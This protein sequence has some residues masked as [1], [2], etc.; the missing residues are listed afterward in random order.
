MEKRKLNIIIFI[1][2]I[3]CSAIAMVYLPDI[4][5]SYFDAKGNII[6]YASK[7]EKLLIYPIVSLLVNALLDF[8]EKRLFDNEHRHISGFFK[9]YF[10][11][12]F[13]FENIKSILNAVDIKVLN[14]TWLILIIEIFIIIISWQYNIL[15]EKSNKNRRRRKRA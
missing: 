1:V 12:F 2:S 6:R 5:P 4:L 8:I 3:M 14:S 13:A 15:I 11:M 7:Y 10:I 9:T